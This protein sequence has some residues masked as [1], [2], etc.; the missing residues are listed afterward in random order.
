MCVPGAVWMDSAFVKAEGHNNKPN[1]LFWWTF[2]GASLG[3]AAHGVVVPS[4]GSSQPAQL[5]GR[6]AWWHGVD[7]KGKSPPARTRV[8]SSQ[9]TFLPVLV[10]LLVR[11]TC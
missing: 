5:C 7:F 10:A 4:P 9:S 1:A 8:F 6:A 3:E 2:K 11:E